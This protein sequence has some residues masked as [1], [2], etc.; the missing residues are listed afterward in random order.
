MDPNSIGSWEINNNY[1]NNYQDKYDE[2]LIENDSYDEKDDIDDEEGT[3]I[4]IARAEEIHHQD[5]L[6]YFR[7]FLPSKVGGKPAWLNPRN[8]PKP[9]DLKCKQCKEPLKFLLQLYAPLQKFDRSFHRTIYI[10]ICRKHECCGKDGTLKVFRS[11]LPL[12]NHFMNPNIIPN[13]T[14]IMMT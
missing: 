4:V 10:F 7:S 2:D 9:R 1:N 6:Y 13:L 3:G 11:Q 12:N 14:M 8:I 5:E